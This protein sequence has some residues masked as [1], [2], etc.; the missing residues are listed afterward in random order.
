MSNRLGGLDEVIRT[1]RGTGGSPASSQVVG[2]VAHAAT[3]SGNPVKIGGKYNSGA[4][5]LTNGQRG[6][7]LQTVNGGQ[8]VT[9]LP[10][11]DA[12]SAVAPTVAQGVSSLVLKASAGNFYSASMVAGA[13][14]GFFILYNATAAPAAAAAITPAQVLAVVPVAANGLASIGGG[15]GIP[16][17]CGTGAVLLFST[18]VTTMTAPANL[19]A[20]M[21]GTAV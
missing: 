20:F 14:A 9:P 5:A 4:V 6:D 18:S 2:N 13:T 3:D 10:T 12:L 19:A 21:R 17:R 8:R 11:T 15:G 16:D 7:M 1:L